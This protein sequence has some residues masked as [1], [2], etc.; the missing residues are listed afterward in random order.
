MYAE[1]RAAAG[2]VAAAKTR[3]AGRSPAPHRDRDR[4]GYS[5]VR[6]Q[7][8]TNMVRGRR[9]REVDQPVAD[10][11]VEP[12]VAEQDAEGRLLPE[13]QSRC[14]AGPMRATA[15]EP[16]GMS[17]HHGSRSSRSWKNHSASA[18]HRED[19]R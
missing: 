1:T 12:A 15:S 9:E 13:D 14:W 10:Q 18:G 3:P 7:L 11:F 19:V 5:V 2:P 6:Q 8:L 4:S 16:T 17:V